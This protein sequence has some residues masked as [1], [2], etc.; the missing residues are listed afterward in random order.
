[1]GA[2]SDGSDRDLLAAQGGLC[3][4]LQAAAMENSQRLVEE[5]PRDSGSPDGI[6]RFLR[7]LLPNSP[8]QAP[9]P[10]R[11]T[12]EVTA[13]MGL[14]STTVRRGLEELVCYGLA[15]F[16]WVTSAIVA[17]ASVQHLAI[18]C[19]DGPD[20][21]PVVPSAPP[22]SWRPPRCRKSPQYAANSLQ[23][24]GRARPR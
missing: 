11:T 15:T 4:A 10:T 6:Y 20:V 14:P 22:R 8:P 19:G 24:A 16:G 23:A 21:P 9:P 2:A 12:T 1:M 17:F 3:F 7:Q 13:A 5:V 18:L